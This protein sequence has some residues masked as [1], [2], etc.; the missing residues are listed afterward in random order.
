MNHKTSKEFTIVGLILILIGVIILIYPTIDTIIRPITG[1]FLMGSSAGKDILFF[2]I[3]GSLAVL[4][5]LFLRIQDN[6]RLDKINSHV[7]IKWMLILGLILILVGV[8]LEVFIRVN[9]GVSLWTTI[10]STIPEPNSS[11]ITHSHIYKAVLSPVLNYFASNN[12]MIHTGS[13]LFTHIP[14]I[15]MI[16]LPVLPVIY[17][18]VPFASKDLLVG[19]KRLLCF[20]STLL[21]ISIIDGGIFSTPGI[22][23]FALLTYLL[24]N[25]N[26]EPFKKISPD[27][28]K[29]GL[30]HSLSFIPAII[31]VI[32]LILT[33]WGFIIGE[34]HL[35][36]TIIQTITGIVCITISYLLYTN[37]PRKLS[38]I[39]KAGLVIAIILILKVILGLCGTSIAYY[40]VTIIQPTETINLTPYDITT[41]KE[42]PNK[43]IIHIAPEYTEL[44]LIE[45]L[46]QQLN[47]SC[48]EFYITWNTYSYLKNNPKDQLI[49]KK[50]GGTEAY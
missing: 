9:S 24:Y 18:L 15:G 47:S 27:I 31:G 43:T 26:K 41:I 32:T 48:S 25:K 2:I 37:Y 12:P 44:N 20:G 34:Y 4:T 38:C 22:I 8:L 17:L 14:P 29:N 35:I 23:S 10:V 33:I 50:I 16:I 19:D 45:S 5:G 1:L 46:T 21:I 40:E 30:I 42:Y 39:D 7:C 13:S 28:I 3:L 11:S 6:A 36:N 49:P